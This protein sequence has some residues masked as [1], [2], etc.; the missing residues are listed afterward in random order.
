MF[1]PPTLGALLWWGSNK[2]TKGG[3]SQDMYKCNESTFLVTDLRDSN[4]KSAKVE[5]GAGER[6]GQ[7]QPDLH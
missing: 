6:S 3:R 4:W 1:K 2:L 7:K 5:A